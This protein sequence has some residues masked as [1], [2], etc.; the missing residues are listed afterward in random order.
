MKKPKQ[1]GDEEP[2]ERGE[3]QRK[4]YTESKFH[5]YD[6]VVQSSRPSEC[7]KIICILDNIDNYRYTGIILNR[8][9]HE[10]SCITGQNFN[11]DL[12]QTV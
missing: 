7:N 8:H 12:Q 6:I 5:N 4:N 11:Y 1:G 3:K 9:G 10:S 2:E